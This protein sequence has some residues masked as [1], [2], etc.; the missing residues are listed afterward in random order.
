MD[1]FLHQFKDNLENQPAPEFDEQDWINMQQ[2]LEHHYKDSIKPTNYWAWV[3]SVLFLMI[4]G[5]TSL[6][7]QKLNKANKQISRLESTIDTLVQTKIIVRTDTIYQFVNGQHMTNSNEDVAS[8]NKTI[9]AR[10]IS[11]IPQARIFANRSISNQLGINSQLPFTKNGQQSSLFIPSSKN[12]IFE[13]IGLQTD[14][15]TNTPNASFGQQGTHTNDITTTSEKKEE[16]IS[17]SPILS[18]IEMNIFSFPTANNILNL[19]SSFERSFIPLKRKKNIQQI[20]YPMR[21]KGIDIGISYGLGMSLAKHHRHQKNQQWEINAQVR[22]SQPIRLWVE[23]SYQSL[24]YESTKKGEQFG[25][26]EIAPPSDNF[27]FD[28]AHVDQN[29][30]SVSTGLQY[31]FRATKK[32][33]PFIGVGFGLSAI[34]SNSARYRF[35]E[36]GIPNPIAIQFEKVNYE[37]ASNLPFGLLKSGIVYQLNNKLSFQLEGGYLQRIENHNNQLSNILTGKIGTSLS[38]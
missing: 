30:I 29:V 27:E 9:L 10:P 4:V 28:E 19:P 12:T 35:E 8:T 33:Q 16:L 11:N 5:S 38:F 3:A 34:T 14:L 32:W 21:P 25:V 18:S 7:L 26:P 36:P 22:F 17:A 15:L 20:L 23:G 13:S 24:S 2:R 31:H 6:I 37:N 1:K